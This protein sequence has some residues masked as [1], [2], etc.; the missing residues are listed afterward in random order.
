M[1]V[2]LPF[3]ALTLSPFEESVIAYGVIVGS[4]FSLGGFHL[5]TNGFRRND[6]QR[7]DIANAFVQV[8]L[9]PQT[10]VQAEYRYNNIDKGDLRQF[11]F[12]ED[13]FP[14]QRNMEERHSYRVGAGAWP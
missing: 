11:F 8:E 13:F 6:D 5:T 14:H 1:R 10:S 4:A 2:L 7:N 9:S 3:V 12:P